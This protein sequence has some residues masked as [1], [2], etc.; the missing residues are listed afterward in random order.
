MN[1]HSILPLL[2]LWIVTPISLYG[3]K[4]TQVDVVIPKYY[5]VNKTSQAIII[6]GKADEEA[7]KDALWTDSFID[8]EGSSKPVPRFATRTKMLWDENY[9]YVYAWM[10]EPHIWGTLTNRDDIIYRNN[11]FEVFIKPNEH[12]AHYVEFE[13]NALNTLW[14][15]MLI[16]PYRLGGPYTSNWDVNGTKTAVHIEGSLNDPTD[17]DQYWSV[18]IAIPLAPINRLSRKNAA[19]HGTMWR[20]NFSRVQWQHELDKGEYKRKRNPENTNQL[21][22]E[23]N[24]VWSPQSAIDMHRPEHWGYLYFSDNELRGDTQIPLSNWNTEYQ[25]LFHLHRQQLSWRKQ[26]GTFITN[27]ADLGGPVFLVDGKSYTVTLENFVGGY[28]FS[29]QNEQHQTL[30][31]NS[32]EELSIIE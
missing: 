1:K 6:D 11:D 16:K 21:L 2:L 14:D 23:D 3:Q 28:T 17:T 13:V 5:A 8:I 15:L 19:K 7:W 10:E 20:I 25:L 27:I 32:N 9:L 29:I 30:V 22:R 18:E 12:F 24:W 31:L 4:A 26:H